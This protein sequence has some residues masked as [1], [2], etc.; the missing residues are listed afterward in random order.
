MAG[1][2]DWGAIRRTLKHRTMILQYFGW[3]PY[4]LVSAAAV[5]HE[6]PLQLFAYDLAVAFGGAIFAVATAVTSQASIQRRT[7]GMQQLLDSR[8]MRRALGTER[9]R[10]EKLLLN[11]LPDTIASELKAAGRIEPVHYDSATV[12]FTDFQGFTQIAE[13]LTARELVTELDRCFSYFDAVTARYN[14]EKLKTIGDSFMCVGGVPTPNHTH[15]VDAVLAALE[16]HFGSLVAG[17]IGERKFAYDV[18]GD[19]VNTASR[20]ESSGVAGRINISG[21]TH[22][23][24]K[25][26]FACEHRG[27]VPA[28]HK[29][30]IDIVLRGWNPA[31]VVAGWGWARA[32]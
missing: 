24:V 30:E 11:I 12:M 20:C 1:W 22:E 16:I 31:G 23:L 15:A 9:D 28:K 13:T 4:Y 19:T 32:G 17:V 7:A 21:A 5:N 2:A 25:D 6:W 3:L 8:R 14:L 18:W 27:A 29:G 26:F 10:S